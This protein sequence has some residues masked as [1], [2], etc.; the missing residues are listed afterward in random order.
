MESFLRH[1][2]SGQQPLDTE[3]QPLPNDVRQRSVEY[4]G[5]FEETFPLDWS[6]KL[7][8]P[9]VSINTN[10]VTANEIRN[11]SPARQLH[12]LWRKIKY[13]H[14]KL[15]TAGR[16]WR[17]DVFECI[18]LT[19]WLILLNAATSVNRHSHSQTLIVNNFQLGDVHSPAGLIATYFTRSEKFEMSMRLFSSEE[20]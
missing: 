4:R 5:L 7:A 3:E 11:G 10:A 2:G 9:M 19:Q 13:F 6:S 8:K 20:C 16:W 1:F 15:E 17:F 14:A 18:A 12:R